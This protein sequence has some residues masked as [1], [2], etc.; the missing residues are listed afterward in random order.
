VILV[1]SLKWDKFLP[2]FGAGKNIVEIA[3]QQ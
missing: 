1:D 3:A 2:T